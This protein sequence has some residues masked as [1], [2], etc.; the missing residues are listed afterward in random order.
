MLRL[1]RAAIVDALEDDSD[2]ALDALG[3]FAAV[4]SE[5]CDKSSSIAAGGT[6]VT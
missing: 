2:M 1:T 4:D 6:T 3:V 5:L